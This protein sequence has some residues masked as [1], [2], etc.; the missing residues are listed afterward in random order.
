VGK[1]WTVTENGVENPWIVPS[2]GD[3]AYQSFADGTNPE[4]VLLCYYSS[5]EFP[6]GKKGVGH[7]PAN[8]YLAH[9]KVRHHPA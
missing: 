9:L 6:V 5:H 1:L 2:G 3:C 4:E 7:N 8:I